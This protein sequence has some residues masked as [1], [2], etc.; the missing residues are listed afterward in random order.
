MII[1]QGDAYGLPIYV[2]VNGQDITE[3]TLYLID[4][5]EVCFDD[6]CKEYKADGSGEVTFADNAF[7]YPLKQ[8]ESLKLTEGP[9]TID[10]RVKDISGEVHGLHYPLRVTVA[11][12]VS[13]R[14]L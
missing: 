14:V 2:E 5:V 6:V 10:I 12:A 4:T 9:G 1:K 3:E 13:R 8:E 7:W 11:D